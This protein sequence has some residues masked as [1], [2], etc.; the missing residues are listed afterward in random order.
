MNGDPQ[1]NYWWWVG[2][3][4]QLVKKLLFGGAPFNLCRHWV[5]QSLSCKIVLLT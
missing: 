4:F 2:D 3:L 5:H 1:V